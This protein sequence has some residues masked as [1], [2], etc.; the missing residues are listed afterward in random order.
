MLGFQPS[1]SRADP[2]LR[3]H[4]FKGGTQ[5]VSKYAD[6][7]TVLGSDRGCAEKGDRARGY[8]GIR[9]G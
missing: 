2:A 4:T 1:K 6:K 7:S 9:G 3:K 5:V 8:R